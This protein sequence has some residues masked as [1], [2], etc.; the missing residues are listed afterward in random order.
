M[1]ENTRSHPTPI[2][3]DS[4]LAALAVILLGAALF[5][6]EEFSH[7]AGFALKAL[8]NTAPFIFFAVLAVA[9]V[10][11]TGAENV[12][13][14]AF[15]GAEARMVILAALLGGL[16]PF[17]SCEVIPFIAALLA[18]GAPLSAVMAFWLASPLMDPAMFLITSGTLG[19]EFALGK[20]MAAVGIGLFGGAVTMIFAK[21]V[22][23]AD[24][25]Q[26]RARNENP[27]PRQRNRKQRAF[28]S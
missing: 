4:A 8:A 11:A 5:N 20:T 18:V 6:F 22:V 24:P 1:A 25:L 21:S 19:W 17:C 16:S 10:K 26:E 12:L 7:V 27:K 2:K 23:F 28:Q 9:Y 14:K 13:A 15:E 3:V